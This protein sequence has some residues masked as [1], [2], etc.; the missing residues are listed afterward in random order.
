MVRSLLSKHSRPVL[1]EVVAGLSLAGCTDPD[2]PKTSF[3]EFMQRRAVDAAAATGGQPS[4]G[5]GEGGGEGGSG[6]ATGGGGGAGGAGAMGCEAAWD[7]SGQY[8]FSLSTF[9]RPDRPMVFGATVV[10]TPAAA[11]TDDN[12][13]TVELTL[14]P[15]YCKASS[16]PEPDC[17][18]ANV[19]SPLPKFTFPAGKDGKFRADLG[20]LTVAGDSNPITGRDITATLILVGSLRDK[21]ICGGVEGEVT[22]PIMSPLTPEDS[23]FGTTWVGELGDDVGEAL[24]TAE[25]RY[26]CGPCQH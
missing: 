24:K 12:A 8:L 19:G 2:A 15:L 3:D 5:G 11:P 25:I 4:P 26:D 22:S 13:G 16:G 23:R 18:R 10:F 21:E 6:G 7:V 17:T 1:V 9:I 20:Q 14:Q